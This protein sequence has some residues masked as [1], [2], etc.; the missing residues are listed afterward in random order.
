MGVKNLQMYGGFAVLSLSA[1]L[2]FPGSGTL[3]VEGFTNYESGNFAEMEQQRGLPVRG[4]LSNAV[5]AEFG[6]PLERKGPVGNPPISSWHYETF[7]VYF[8]HQMVITSI[9][10]ED[11]L[12]TELD[13]IQ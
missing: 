2:L 7:D 10:K 9:D 3:R 1:A 6:E 12:P 5:L 8:E 11:I 4:T 13:G